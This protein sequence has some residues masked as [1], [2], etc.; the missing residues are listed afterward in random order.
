MNQNHT[1]T[2]S[3]C[4]NILTKNNLKCS[5][6]SQHFH[7]VCAQVPH[8]FIKDNPEKIVNWFC[9]ECSKIFPFYDISNSEIDILNTSDSV[10]NSTFLY[11]AIEKYKDLEYDKENEIP[12]NSF[13]HNIDPDYNFYSN[14][15]KECQYYTEQHFDT[16]LREINGF[17]LIHFNARSLQANCT[18]IDCYLKLL[19]KSFDIIAISETWQSDSNQVI[20]F[21]TDYTPYSVNRTN[22]RGGGVAIYVKNGLS[23]KLVE[24]LSH[25]YE[26]LFEC[27]TIE[28][29]SKSKRST[30][31]SCIYRK[32]GTSIA[33]FSDIIEELFGNCKNKNMYLCGDLNIDFLKYETHEHTK[34][35]IDALFSLGLFPLINKP[36]RITT[37]TETLI[38]N[39]FTNILSAHHNSG[40]LITDVSDHL[41]IFTI[42]SRSTSPVSEPEFITKRKITGKTVDNLK[43][44]LNK[45]NWT[46][47]YQSDDVNKAYNEFT[48]ILLKCLD[49]CC[50][51]IKIEVN[52]SPKNKSKPWF[53]K[54]LKN[55]CKKKNALYKKFLKSKNSIDETKYKTYKNKLTTILRNCEK[56]YY[57]RLFESTK[58]DVKKTW[59][60]INDLIKPKTKNGDQ[61]KDLISGNKTETD[62][63]NEFN[64][65]FTNIGP[66][67][68]DTIDSTSKTYDKFMRESVRNNMFIKPVTEEELLSTIKNIESKTSLDY[69]GV[70]MRLVKQILPTIMYQFLDICNKSFQQGI[71]PD[72]MKLAK[73]IPI[74][75]SGDKSSYNNYRPISLL[76]QFSK[77]LE[78]LF[79]T[80]L[81]AF[82]DK[83]EILDS[84]QYGFQKN[85]STSSAVLELIEEIANNTEQKK[86]TA[87]IL[88][89]LKKAFDTVNH[90]I[91]IKKLNTMD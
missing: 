30:L 16:Q 61:F 77:I 22:H 36:T 79:T 2:C 56:S 72:A 57:E 54:T 59:G 5:I 3:I 41:P 44:Y 48:N 10:L 31:V 62:V 34:H 8:N 55:A 28:I 64:H 80:R 91:L 33:E 85:R 21:L 7:P 6:C 11:T 26:N 1:S 49:K 86:V 39:I 47:V 27:V 29:N 46:P 82:L 42:D 37:S 83:N 40:I 84:S 19:N 35:F 90:D 66:K 50:P 25:S 24:K 71:F 63:A 9:V 69:L 74:F 43:D 15:H 18:K 81:D 67:L 51:E 32:P 76:P 78:K 20:N 75:K 73:I 88:I 68:A 87:S 12:K 4:N 45:E 13:D 17:S 53:T 58:G 70:S 89:D 52:Q 38:D 14:I 65:F 60:I 23:C